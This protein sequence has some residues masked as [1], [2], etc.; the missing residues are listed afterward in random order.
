MLV[1]LLLNLVA[2]A[3][4]RMGWLGHS[5]VRGEP[6]RLTNQ[7][8][9]DAIEPGARPDPRAMQRPGARSNIP[10]A[11]D[12]AERTPAPR[13]ETPAPPVVESC[14][15]YSLRGR[16]T[17]A[18]VSTLIEPSRST[19]V[20]SQQT[21]EE[22]ANWRVRIPPAA[23]PEAGEQRLATLQQRGVSDM[24]L[25]RGEGPNR[26]SISLGLFSTETAAEQRLESLRAQGVNSAEIVPGT[27]G[28]Y[29]IELRGPQAV[30]DA[31]SPRL[32]TLLGSDARETCSP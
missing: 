4:G 19:I 14:V 11:A 15:A 13:A 10:Q 32:D 3:G 29:R 5:D 30:I 23:S 12:V 24:Y 22:P 16:N 6:E 27:I 18:E 8:R 20:L 9:P 1:L 17:L 25:I 26:W 7:I 28:R 31:V 2:F 21:L